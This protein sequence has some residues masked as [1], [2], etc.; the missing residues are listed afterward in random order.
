MYI[1]LKFFKLKKNF[2][3][4]STY[5]YSPTKTAKL[6][7][8][9]KPSAGEN[10]EQLELLVE[11]KLVKSSWKTIWQYLLKLMDGVP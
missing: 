4:T 8:P 3:P 11:C 5:H 1:L 6:K 2:K 10:V 7:R 9:T